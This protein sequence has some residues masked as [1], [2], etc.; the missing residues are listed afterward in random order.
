MKLTCNCSIEA[1][2]FEQLEEHIFPRV[3]ESYNINLIQRR[4]FCHTWVLTLEK[5]FVRWHLLTVWMSKY[6]FCSCSEKHIGEIR[7]NCTFRTPHTI[8]HEDQAEC[9]DRGGSDSSLRHIRNLC[10]WK[11][12][13]DKMRV[14][15]DLWL[16]GFSDCKQ[17]R[18]FGTDSF[19]SNIAVTLEF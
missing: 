11:E 4:L 10:T 18:T 7:Q 2:S 9:P 13:S 5:W 16:T 17:A 1:T 14:V 3:I 12:R 8:G 19:E 15:S 6:S